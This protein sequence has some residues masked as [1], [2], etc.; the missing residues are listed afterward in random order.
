VDFGDRLPA[1]MTPSADL[2]QR[3]TVG[4]R[5]PP[6]RIDKDGFRHFEAVSSPPAPIR[7]SQTDTALG[8]AVEA[9]GDF[10]AG[11]TAALGRDAAESVSRAQ[12]PF[13]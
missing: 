13:P 8:A 11:L 6:A 9:I 12:K 2:W 3:W 10:L 7:P 1:L 4:D 5:E